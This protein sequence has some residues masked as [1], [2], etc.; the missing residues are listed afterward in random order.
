MTRKDILSET[1][2][3]ISNW[4]LYKTWKDKFYTAKSFEKNLTKF[5]N[6]S[7]PKGLVQ[8]EIDKW[9]NRN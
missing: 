4:H 3:D 2:N 9:S 8:F 1:E 6:P 7:K 5:H